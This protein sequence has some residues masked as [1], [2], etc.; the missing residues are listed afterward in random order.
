M[1]L[2]VPITIATEAVLIRDALL[3]Y[4]QPRGATVDVVA[5]QAQLWQVVADQTVQSTPKLVLCYDG[6]TTRGTFATQDD[7]HRVDRKWIVVVMRGNGWANPLI[8][9]GAE[10]GQVIEPFY[11]TVEAI[12]DLLRCLLTISDEVFPNYTGISSLP[13]LGPSQTA[14]AFLA[15]YKISFTTANDIGQVTIA[16]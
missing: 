4:A 8:E 2:S 5:H 14:N 13:G 3:A 7:L 16:T 11:D 1:S 12:R 15:G 10:Q 9:A 6:E